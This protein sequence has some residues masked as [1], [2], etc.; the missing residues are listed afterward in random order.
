[1]AERFI[2]TGIKRRVDWGEGK[3][4]QPFAGSFI[5]FQSQK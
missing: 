3:A 4:E 1:M 2:K 5:Y